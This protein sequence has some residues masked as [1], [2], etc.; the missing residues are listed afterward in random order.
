MKLLLTLLLLAATAQAETIPLRLVI[1]K[2]PWATPAEQLI[3]AKQGLARLK[4]TGVTPKI[5]SVKITRDLL[6][7]NKTTQYV[8]R[9]DSWQNLA[10]R[11]GWCKE[12][13]V[14]FMLLPPIFDGKYYYQGGVADS[15]CVPYDAAYVIVRMRNEDGSPKVKAS[16]TAVAHEFGHLMGTEHDEEDKPYIM[17]PAALKFGEATLP[18][19][20]FSKDLVDV[21][22]V[23]EKIRATSIYGFGNPNFKGAKTRSFKGKVVEPMIK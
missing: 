10:Y 5:S 2:H 21:C 12:G 15:V 17:H 6:N 1:V 4:E 3:L 23:E 14:C 18:W 8:G 11:K 16:I 22:L 19:S 9:L 7:R 13:E 20:Q